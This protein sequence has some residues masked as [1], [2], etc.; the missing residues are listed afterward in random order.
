MTAEFDDVAFDEEED[1][2]AEIDARGKRVQNVGGSGTSKKKPRHVGPMDAFVSPPKS[3]QIGNSGKGVQTI[4]DAYK[5]ELREK[6]HV[7]IARWMYE[8]AIP[9]NVV[10]Y[11]S[12][13]VAIQ[14]IG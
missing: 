9:F 3:T 11:D 8:A 2:V 13:N 5:K 1:E 7:D 10:N 4:N 6:A 14:S 12:F